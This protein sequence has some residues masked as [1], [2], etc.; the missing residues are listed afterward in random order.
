MR[1]LSLFLISVILIGCSN[2]QETENDI[3]KNE[4]DKE[5]IEVG[6]E[7]VNNLEEEFSNY[8]ETMKVNGGVLLTKQLLYHVLADKVVQDSA[9]YVVKSKTYPLMTEEVI[10]NIE[11]LNLPKE[12]LDNS[13]EIIIPSSM[14]PENAGENLPYYLFG[15]LGIPNIKDV[16]LAEDN[17]AI[18]TMTFLEQQ[19]FLSIF[20]YLADYTIDTKNLTENI[21]LTEDLKTVSV[22]VKNK[23]Y[24]TEEL[25]SNLQESLFFAYLYQIYSKDNKAINILIK[26]EETN[27]VY[28]TVNYYF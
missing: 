9:G 20:K 5:I 23:S 26:N 14:L 19:T 28:E 25:V 21:I 17:S 15:V 7:Q 22:Y 12:L 10:L 13:V 2:T 27:E 8:E 3:D 11:R 4:K 1:I 16:K 6:S 18:M 24:N